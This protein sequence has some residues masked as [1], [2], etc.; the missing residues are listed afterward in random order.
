MNVAKFNLPR[1]TNVEPPSTGVDL[2]QLIDTF[3][4]HPRLLAAIALVVL[5]VVAIFTLNQT[6]RYTATSSVVIDTRKH[7]IA[8]I[9]EVVSGLPP[10]GTGID[11][12]VEIMR[13]RGLAE[14]V[15]QALRLDS[16]PEFSVPKTN[17]LS[18]IRERMATLARKARHPAAGTPVANY[19]Q[20]YAHEA[21]I[22]NVLRRLKV[23]RNGLTFV[24]D[25]SFQSRDA[26]KA[27]L[28]ANTFADRYLTEQ[29]QDKYDATQQATQWL[30]DRLAELQPQVEQAETAVEQYKAQH[31]LLSSVGPSL[32]E[33]EISSLNG[34]LAQALADQAERES[35]LNTTQQQIAAG[36]T[37]ED[38]SGV[39]ASETIREL[40]T[41]K[42]AISSKVAELQTKYGPR[43]PE[44]QSAQRQ[45][46]D[47][48]AQ[49]RQEIAR[50]VSSL[51]AEAKVAEGRTA[52]I[53][54]SLSR[55]KGTLIGNNAA[56]VQLADL[57][58]KANAASTLYDSLLNRAKQTSTD[59][60]IEQS[61]A[62]VLARASIP[63]TPSFPNKQLD[64]AAA[65]GLALVSAAGAAFLL[66]TMESSLATSE[67]VT[68]R[69][70]VP[71][72]GSLPKLASTVQRKLA[73]KT[74][75]GRYVVEK[76]LS[77]FAEAFR[78]LRT[79]IMFSRLDGP[80]KVVMV[81][82]ALPGE[83]KTTTTFCLGRSAAMSGVKVVVVDCDLRRRGMNRLLG[84]EPEHGLIEV[85]QGAAKL[86]EALVLDEPSGAYFLPLMESPQTSKDLFGSIAMDRL[87]AALRERFDLVLM[88]TAPVIPISDTRVLAS[89]VD[90]VVF[91]AQWRKTPRKAIES[92]FAVLNS[93]DADIAGVALTLVDARQQAKYGYSDSS[94]YYQSYRN[95]YSQ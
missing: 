53:Q 65:F 49:I 1:S 58:R 69:L 50:Q 89:K 42:S 41:Q 47:V 66:A 24:I 60:G 95:Y 23:R 48:E 83:G 34:Q 51:Q 78:N 88:D 52:S 5:V 92:A 6:P 31:G 73:A 15:V 13:S 17:T 93:V 85:L 33:Q 43:Y 64:F 29:L 79:A 44:V 28:I 40:R 35:R 86:D 74:P 12:E 45:L 75:P 26:A 90:I 14:R 10:D 22:D 3:R 2:R 8:N 56:T 39:L 32:T 36:S 71:Y 81:T 37:G 16:D 76:P 4:R 38:F 77:A 11:T 57:Q 9:Q 61:D 82:S 80:G 62:R 72:L 27:A 30:N 84:I 94:Y 54:A 68:R 18:S 70:G 19:T 91:L 67:D 87:I 20:V 59:Q 55:A 63:I 46:T 25:I 7:D 21:V